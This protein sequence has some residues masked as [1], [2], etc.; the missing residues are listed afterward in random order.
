[1]AVVE[2]ITDGYGAVIG[3]AERD[4][5][6]VSKI[7][8]MTLLVAQIKNQDPMS[9]MDNSEFT[10]QITQFSMLEEMQGLGD[11][12]DDN[13][14]VG[15][16]LNNTAML[17]LVGKDVTVEGNKVTLAEGQ[18]TETVLAADSG[19]RAV[20]EVTDE[21]GHVVRTYETNIT[22]GLNSVTWDGE[23]DNGE[24]AADGT[25]TVSVSVTDNSDNAVGFTTLMTGPVEGLRY[26]NNVAIVQVGGQEYYVSEIYK[27]S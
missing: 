24:T 15:Q 13:L 9:P 23:L 22:Q 20:I 19:G 2:G 4:Y 3:A 11:K 8:F 6:Q 1:M 14:L 27:V 17:A 18:A 26:E 25:Y 5:S 7:D 12:M 10:S 21:T 16:S